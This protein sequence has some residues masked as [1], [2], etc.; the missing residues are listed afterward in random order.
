MS[1]K[2]IIPK[3]LIRRTLY[4]TI[5]MCTVFL[6]LIIRVTYI[7]SVNSN[8]YTQKLENQNN[9]IVNLNSGRG[10][11]YDRNNIALTDTKKTSVVVV[12]KIEYIKNEEIKEI[13]IDIAESHNQK[14]GEI[15][16]KINK[17][18]LDTSS[19][20]IE[21]EA[22]YISDNIKSKLKEYNVMVKDKIHRYSDENLLSHTIGYTRKSDNIGVSGIEG[23]Y[24][25]ILQDSNEDY[26]SV[27]KAG[28]SGNFNNEHISSLEGTVEVVENNEEDTHI[29]LTIDKD[30]QR[31]VENAVDKIYKNSA[32]VV[33]EVET[34]EIVALSSRPNYDQ[35]NPPLDGSASFNRATQ[36]LYEPG[37]VFKIVVLYAALENNIINE[38]Y[39]YT[40]S[41]HIDNSD[42]DEIIHCANHKEHGT[43]TLEQCFSNSCNNAFYDIALKVGNKKIIEAAKKLH[44]DEKLE[45]GIQE[46]YD[47]ISEDVS[48]KFLAI[49]QGEL[50]FTPIQINQLTQIVANN[51]T[52]EPLCLY[53]S[54]IDSEFNII[55]K[56]K[57][58]K[59]EEI[60]N[61]YIMTIIKD[62]MKSVSEYGT[63]KVLNELEGGCGVKTGTAQVTDT[64][65]NG[66]VT[67]FYPKENPKYSIT[68]LLEDVDGSQD[69]I[70]LFEEI[71]TNIN[72]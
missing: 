35:D 30:I 24:N 50:R 17:Q 66:W 39:T 53:D 22:D 36:G 12:D 55:E 70:P 56:F 47:P 16:E 46:S 38:D 15:L 32:V 21:F 26:I 72:K 42:G 9:E 3:L 57:T 28:Q 41:G 5:L 13:F 37:S 65:N 31:I 59:Q 58:T 6:L 67:G 48:T 54:V 23:N 2:T 49:G 7:M 1:R 4:I 63:A 68:V 61:P 27:F 51:G 25:D 62:M 20:I 34:G 43:Q 60:I 71:C 8:E 29:R 45:I 14:G 52:Y 11:I 33:S 44:L 19:V 69:A 18:V 40:C 10:I 64:K